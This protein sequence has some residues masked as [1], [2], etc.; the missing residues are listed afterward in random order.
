MVITNEKKNKVNRNVRLEISS[1][2]IS[3]D[4]MYTWPN[5]NLIT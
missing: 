4:I 3:E 1:K 5:L 2:P